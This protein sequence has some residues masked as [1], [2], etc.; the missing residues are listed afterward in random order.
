MKEITIYFESSDD[1]TLE[2]EVNES[3]VVMDD[4]KRTRS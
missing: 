4:G 3:S 1:E 2:L